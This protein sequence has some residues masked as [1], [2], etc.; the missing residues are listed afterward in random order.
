MPVVLTSARVDQTPADVS[1]T[2]RPS[3][4]PCTA[5]TSTGRRPRRSKARSYSAKYPLTTS[6]DGRA[7]SASASSMPGSACIP[8]TL[9]Y[10]SEGHRNCQASPGPGEW[11][12]TTKSRSGSNPVRRR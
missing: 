3:V 1:T 2:S 5:R 9:P 10:V 4:P 11:S 6:A 12:S 8:C 7:G